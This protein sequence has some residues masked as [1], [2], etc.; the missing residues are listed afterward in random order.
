MGRSYAKRAA[1]KSEMRAQ[2]NENGC[3]ALPS[4]RHAQGTVRIT[5]T[6]DSRLKK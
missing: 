5:A 4:R 6:V 2:T 1:R 3:G